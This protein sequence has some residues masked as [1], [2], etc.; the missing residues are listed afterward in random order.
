[1][2]VDQ[3][4]A[5]RTPLRP[6]PRRGALSLA[7]VRLLALRRKAGGQRDVINDFYACMWTISRSPKGHRLAAGRASLRGRNGRPGKPPQVLEKARNRPGNAIAAQELPGA[8]WRL[9]TAPGGRSRPEKPPQP[10]ENTQNRLGNERGARRSVLATRPKGG[11]AIRGDLGARPSPGSPRPFGARDDGA[12]AGR[13]RRR[14]SAPGARPEKSPQPIE[15]AQN[16]LGARARMAAE[17]SGRGAR[18]ASRPSVVRE[19]W[20]KALKGLNPRPEIQS[21]PPRWRRPGETR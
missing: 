21:P 6:P 16:R 20:R 2:P 3:P 10:L 5:R 12:G 11:A 9:C 4:A 8:P 17:P 19:N 15:K 18:G 7:P 13:S 1:M 14:A